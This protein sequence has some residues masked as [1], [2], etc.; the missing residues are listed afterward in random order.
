MEEADQHCRKSNFVAEVPVPLDTLFS[1]S[2]GTLH[3]YLQ[4]DG[5][6]FEDART[7]WKA[8]L[9]SL[10]TPTLSEKQTTSTC[11]CIRIFLKS[12]STVKLLSVRNVPL[13]RHAWL[14]CYHAVCDA[15]SR[16]K[17]KPL[18]QVLEVLLQAAKK[19]MPGNE[20]NSLWRIISLELSAVILSGE[21]SRHLKG[22]LAL[23]AFFLDKNM[24]YETY[25]LSAG[26][27][28]R[29]GGEDDKTTSEIIKSL[30]NSVLVAFERHD[31]QN[32]AEKFFKALLKAEHASDLH[33]WWSLVRDFVVDHVDSLDTIATSVFPVLLEQ[34][35]SSELDAIVSNCDCENQAG[36]LFHVALLQSLRDREAIS[37]SGAYWIQRSR[38]Q[39]TCIPDLLELIQR[40]NTGR[41][42]GA[43]DV[44]ELLLSHAD[45]GVRVR[46]L[47]LLVTSKMT[48]APVSL[49]ILR[50]VQTNVA[51]WFRPGG[52]HERG[53][54]LSIVRRLLIRLRGGSSVLEKTASTSPLDME[55][56]NI[57]KDF[58][59]ALLTSV[60]S[61]LRSNA[62]YQRHIIGLSILRYLFESN[63]DACDRSILQT[64]NDP[65]WPFSLCLRQASMVQDLLNLVS[66]AY[67]DVRA[68]SAS[69]LRHLL[70]RRPNI[71][72]QQFSKQLQTAIEL[73]IPTL[74][75]EAA[76]T[77]RSDQADGLG[78]FY[79]LV[80]L[81]RQCT[82]GSQKVDPPFTM[83]LV[84]RLER[85]L[86]A[87]PI[88]EKPG[89]EPLHSL[90]LGVMYC[91][92]D[93]SD[94]L[95]AHDR[96][97]SISR[98][99]WRAVAD[100]LCVDSPETETSDAEDVAEEVGT[101]PKDMLSYGWRALRDSR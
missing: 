37:Q 35:T 48:N 100:H 93:A 79:S 95:E 96:I 19:T 72:S 34:G 85:I 26:Q 36:L 30:I 56:L 68:L 40:M 74:E 81:T 5:L 63:I 17:V 38:T 98:Q 92:E 52:S 86:T 67:E 46:V 71:R 76:Q 87:Q 10:S 62:S 64:T 50:H 14:D 88:L 47:R 22:A 39:L 7:I 58:V 90:L 80:A 94:G 44:P 97:I 25:L 78:R 101:G 6:T 84:D 9:S 12:I 27:N 83:T 16:A 82:D 99:V 61:E 2:R 4:Q 20:L 42:S 66:D 13:V 3:E 45:D 49:P 31:A 57:H 70:C 1:W 21:P 54:L 59:E 24:S 75:K 89:A 69:I 53:E 73:L 43:I 51:L 23:S 33:L 28:M 29:L 15:W 77:N 32:A 8:L 18:V 55:L 60:V 41:N 11:N 91:V 65:D